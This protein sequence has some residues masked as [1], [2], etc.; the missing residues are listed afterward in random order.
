MAVL[1]TGGAG[2]IG[3]HVALEFLEAGEHAVVLDDLSTGFR[4]AIPANTPFVFG[5]AG[6]QGLVERLIVEHGVSAIVHLAAQTS[7]PASLADPLS[8]YDVNFAQMRSLVAAAVKTGVRHFVYS[9]TAAVYGTPGRN[10][11]S[12]QAPALPLTPYGRSKLMGEW[13]LEDV[14]QAHG[15]TYVALRYFNVA[16]ADPLGRAG[17]STLNATNLIK[18]AVQTALGLRSG[19]EVFGTDYPTRDG[20]CVRDFVQVT[21]LARGHMSALE[22]LRSGG[23]RLVCNCGYGIGYSVLEVVEAVKRASGSDFEVRFVDRRPGDAAEVVASSALMREAL[24]WTPQFEDL[25]TMVEQAL[26][27]EKRSVASRTV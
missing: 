15:L 12:E 19:F 23:D 27:W 26:A 16:G 6:D 2:Y 18:A 20:S 1:I 3:S 5:R 25:T 8:Y 10:P 17:Q 21:D 9:S 4:S 7:A 24:R 14:A 11:V 13:L 22:H